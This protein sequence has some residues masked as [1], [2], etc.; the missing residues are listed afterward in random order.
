MGAPHQSLTLP[1]KVR[2]PDTGPCEP[3]T[4]TPLGVWDAISIVVGIVVGAG[5]FKSP[6]G[7]FAQ[8]S[9]PGTALLAWVVGGLLSLAGALCFAEL[10]SAFPR[11]GGEYVYLTRAFGPWAGFLFAWAQLAVI[12]TGTIASVSYVFA[13]YAAPALGLDR[14][15]IVPLAIGVIVL[16]TTINVLG[17]NPGRRTQNL[18]TLLKV[19]ALA[20]II[21]AGFLGK[22]PAPAE[23]ALD[24]E[25]AS[26]AL[27]MVFVLYAYGGWHE[28]AYVT[29]EVRNRRRNVPLALV[30]G[31]AAVMVLYVLINAAW[32]AGFGFE[33]AGRPGA[34][35]A[36]LLAGALGPAAGRAMAA[37]VMLSALGSV[38]GTIFTGARI[39]RELGTDHALFAP[40]G[41][42]SARFGTP[43]RS[44]V[45]QAVVSVALVLVAGWLLPACLPGEKPSDPFDVL[46]IGTAPVFFLSFLLTGLSLFVFRARAPGFRPPF[47]VPLYPL[48]PVLF[49][50][51]CAYMLAGSIIGAWQKGLVGLAV[52]AA[53][54]P[55][56]LVSR[57]RDAGPATPE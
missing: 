44:L 24:G 30:G 10:A 48:V 55:L 22:A 34:T 51:A 38:N 4:S 50:G 18:L 52:L 28:A 36:G 8:A 25:H 3:Q 33:A 41:V 43:L 35:A 53:G 14:G 9:G 2:V 54:L 6:A 7:V 31:T 27:A 32:L 26:L 39:Y 49:C 37:L 17:V 12:R 57:R 13:E 5:I 42:C 23:E 19:L 11:S 15:A 56:W 20:G 45:V 16:L 46:V 29:A 40:L 21:L 47:A 1:E